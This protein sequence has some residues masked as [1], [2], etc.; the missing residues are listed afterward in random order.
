MV[1]GGIIDEAFQLSNK[2]EPDFDQD[3]IYDDYILNHELKRHYVPH[4]VVQLDTA[5]QCN[6]QSFPDDRSSETESQPRI[7]TLDSTS[8]DNYEV[9]EEACKRHDKEKNTSNSLNYEQINSKISNLIANRESKPAFKDQNFELQN[10]GIAKKGR[11]EIYT[12]DIPNGRF[13]QSFGGAGYLPPPMEDCELPVETWKGREG[14]WMVKNLFALGLAFM[15]HYIAM[16]GANNLQSSVNAEE[17][18]GTAALTSYYAGFLFSNIFLP[19]VI[20]RWLGCKCTL[21]VSILAY[22][23]YIAAQ[24][25]PRFYTLVPGGVLAGLAAGPLWVAQGTYLSHIADTY[26]Q[27][28]GIPK[29]VIMVRGFGIFYMMY[30]MSQVWGNLISST[31]LS[32]GDTDLGLTSQH[33]GTSSVCGANFCP[34]SAESVGNLKIE[35]PP[36][37]K[38]YLITAI[39]LA[40]MV[41]ASL[42]IIFGMDS[43]KRKANKEQSNQSS[44]HI[45]AATLR[46]LGTKEQWLLIPMTT[47]LGVQDAFMAADYTS[48]YVS[49]AWGIRH[50]GY[51]MICYGVANCVSAFSGG[52]IV[53]LTGRL[54]VVLLATVLQT[55]TVAILLIWKP[56]PK[57]VIIFFTMAALW[58]ATDGI[59]QAQINAMYGIIFPGREEAAYSGFRLWEGVGYIIAFGYSSSLCT[60]MKLYALFG[61]LLL[62]VIGYVVIELSLRPKAKSSS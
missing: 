55:A 54:P 36:Q 7:S 4:G 3:N 11:S 56:D 2:I 5:D 41:M 48:S 28:A 53:K 10:I 51:V 39:Y 15:V 29:D 37:E 31:V 59:W 42:I 23:P 34:R 21:A 57:D 19:A 1:Q 32:H 60:G 13:I 43:L 17:G 50:I 45:L 27:R 12:N 6:N 18:L 9:K 22:L 61:I 25:H 47:W 16:K 20:I 46:L 24:F 26:S 38:I 33:N 40:C 14:C 52:W 8:T 62:G 44:L 35:S 30:Q 49:C 58:G